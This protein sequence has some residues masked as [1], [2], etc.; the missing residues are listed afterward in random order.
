M[1]TR[2][3]LIGTAVFAMALM[4]CGAIFDSIA[5]SKGHGTAPAVLP[6]RVTV[7]D[8]TTGAVIWRSFAGPARVVI[9]PATGGVVSSSG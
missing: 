7:L 1:T 5:P 6:A 4:G 3:A 2:A 8:P 9:N